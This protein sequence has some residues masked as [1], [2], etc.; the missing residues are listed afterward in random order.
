MSVHI[1]GIG[2]GTV[3]GTQ[4]VLCASALIIYLMNHPVLL[5]CFQRSV[6]CGAVGSGKM[7]FKISE[8]DRSLSIGQIFKNHEPHG[9]GLDI[10]RFESMFC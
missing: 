4:S 1:V 9:G 3:F 7:L 10:S 5:E 8:A 6:E 2:T